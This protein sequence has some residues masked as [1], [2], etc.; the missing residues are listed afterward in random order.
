VTMLSRKQ[1]SNWARY[2]IK[3]LKE[4]MQPPKSITALSSIFNDLPKVMRTT[5]NNRILQ[6]ADAAHAKC[7][8]KRIIRKTNI[9]YTSEQ[10][11]VLSKAWTRGFLSDSKHYGSLSK[12]TGLTRKQISNWARLKINRGDKKGITR[13]NVCANSFFKQLSDVMQKD[14]IIVPADE[15]K[16]ES[17]NQKIKSQHLEETSSSLRYSDV[18]NGSTL[19]AP[20][21]N[22]CILNIP[23][24]LVFTGAYKP[25][26]DEYQIESRQWSNEK[27]I[28]SK[29]SDFLMSP[30]KEWVLRNALKGINEVHDRQLED[31]ALLTS[32]SRSEVTLYLLH[33]GWKMFPANIGIRYVRTE[34]KIFSEARNSLVQV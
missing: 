2:Q 20:P 29:L 8:N 9:P 19:S 24:S 10:R 7:Q 25:T 26:R 31:L 12:I 28:S 30:I 15:L 1:I 22:D 23:E 4:N 27:V 16:K 13:I 21:N 11:E 6:A 5:R 3:R 34:Q 17:Q 14:T 32:N 18:A 33:Q